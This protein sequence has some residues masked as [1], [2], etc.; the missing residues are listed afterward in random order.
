MIAR[1]EAEAL[2]SA[3]LR[4]V[5]RIELD[6]EAVHRPNNTAR[7]LGRLPLRVRKS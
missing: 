1:Q 3:L 2:I 7:R 5:D 6:G 4:H